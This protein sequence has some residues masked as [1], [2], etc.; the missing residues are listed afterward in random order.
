MCIGDLPIM[1][2]SMNTSTLISRTN[3]QLLVIQKDDFLDIFVNSKI[4]D[5]GNSERS[6]DNIDFLRSLDLFKDWPLCLFEENFQSIKGCFYKRNQIMTHDSSISK[7]LYIV[8]SGYM[9]V[10][11]KLDF[12]NS[13]LKNSTSKEREATKD[14]AETD[15]RS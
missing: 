7:Y 2:E 3:V 14:E 1:S 5:S 11:T 10:W 12:K 6:T 4:D 9:S 13:F 15:E 8:K